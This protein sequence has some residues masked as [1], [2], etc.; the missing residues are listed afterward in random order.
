[1]TKYAMALVGVLVLAACA[2]ATPLTAP[3]PVRYHTS[4]SAAQ[5]LQT[6]S[7]ALIANGFDIAQSDAT[8]GVI[9]ATMTKSPANLGSAVTCRFPMS[10]M[11]ATMGR[12]TVR[13]NVSAHPGATG[14]SDVL[15]A[16]RVRTDYSKTIGELKGT[17]TSET[18]CVSTGTLEAELLKGVG[19]RP[20]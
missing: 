19:D 18:D 15:I 9:G 20:R 16:T 14:G 8:T 6:V 5:V 2:P 4:E 3:G 10:S 17:P 13:V 11:A 7:D 12:A 1:M